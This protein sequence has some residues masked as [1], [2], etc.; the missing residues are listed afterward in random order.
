MIGIEQPNPSPTCPVWWALALAL[1]TA[2][3]GLYYRHFVHTRWLVKPRPP[4]S[5]LA[6][7]N[8]G[9]NP[10]AYIEYGRR[11]RTGFA[12]GIKATLERNEQLLRQPEDLASFAQEVQQ[13]LQGFDGQPV[14]RI[15]RGAHYQ[16]SQAQR[17]C[18]ESI[19]LLRQGKGAQATHKAA[20]ARAAGESGVGEFRRIWNSAGTAYQD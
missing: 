3:L 2:S 6:F 9:Q 14:P 4:N 11:M 8:H 1:A 15:M 18:L 16:I 7:F 20:L 17:L 13:N 10:A 19:A 5:P 12:L